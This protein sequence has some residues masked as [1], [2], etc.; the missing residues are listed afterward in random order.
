MARQPRFRASFDQAA[1]RKMVQKFGVDSGRE[2]VREGMPDAANQALGKCI[3]L[4]PFDTGALEDSGAV[5]QLR[6]NR[7]SASAAITFD[8]PYAAIVHEMPEA[9]RGPGTISK[10]GNEFGSAGPKY[11]ERVLRGFKFAEVIAEKLRE[12]WARRG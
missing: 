10:P 7:K 1:L 8:A 12:A 11:I 4:A 2:A 9:S 5:T 6:T 3:D